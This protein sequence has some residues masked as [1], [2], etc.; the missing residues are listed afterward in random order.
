MTMSV[1]DGVIARY[2]E[3]LPFAGSARISPSAK[4]ARRS[5]ALPSW[6]PKPAFVKSG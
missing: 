3:F 4:A 1:P 5:S 2:L 6:R